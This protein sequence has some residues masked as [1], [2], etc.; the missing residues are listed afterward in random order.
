MV[1]EPELAGEETRSFFKSFQIDPEL[2]DTAGPKFVVASDFDQDGLTDLV[3][4]WNQSQPVQ[5]HLQRRDA[6][7]NLSFRT[8]TLAGTT[9]VG[10]IAGVEVG[11]LNGDLFPDV[12]VLVKATG[13]ATFCPPDDPASPPEELGALDGEILVYFNPASSS[14]VPDG[15]SWVEMTIINPYVADNWIHDQFP[16]RETK[17]FE[18]MKTQPEWGGYTSL[19]V[20]D[21]DGQDGDDILVALNPAECENLGQL[22]PVNT[23][24]LW[25]NPGAALANQSDQWGTI[26]PGNPG[27]RVP[28]TL[29]ADVPDVK[30]LAVMDIDS[31]GDLD[32]IATFTNAISLNIRWVRNPA[33]PHALGG[34]SGQAAVSSAF[35]DGFRFYVDQ[36][37][38]RPIGQVDTA[39]D[40]LAIGDIDGDGFDDIV[41]RSNVGQIVQWFRRPNALSI[42]PEFPPNDTVPSRFDFPWPVFTLAE[43]RGREPEAIAVGDVTGDGRVELVAAAGGTVYWYDGTTSSS[44]YNPWFANTIVQDNSNDIDGDG[45]EDALDGCPTDPN[46]I[47][48]G[49]CGCGLADPDCSTPNL[50]VAT[51][52]VNTLLLVDLDNDEK[53]DIVGT[54]D[55][56]AG[57]GLSDD[58]L[59]WYRNTRTDVTE[60]V[61]PSPEKF[62]AR[63]PVGGR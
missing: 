36:W 47:E 33:V 24:D 5:I 43:F 19:I 22:P 37:E 26:D 18:V 7:G 49:I 15:D 63:D 27:R 20:A 2:E 25:L 32:V 44:V 58:E 1:D 9:P 16:G 46:K 29:M 61:R 4:G 45:L 57:A 21:I 12:V 62:G 39:A 53:L 10:V 8:V 40:V 38:L 23:V 13:F 30:D 3:S 48:P 35:S 59:V 28:L 34:P 17:E 41:V 60:A 11:N 51:T 56:R 54:L 6:Q 50:A 42:Q 55:R 14:L 52:H 31:D